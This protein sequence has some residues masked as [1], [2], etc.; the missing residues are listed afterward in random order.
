[1]HLPVSSLTSKY[2]DR[3]LKIS[4]EP[5]SQEIPSSQVNVEEAIRQLTEIHAQ[6]SK[7]GLRKP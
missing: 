3:R 2:S 4:T 7:E 5:R 1:M 6:H